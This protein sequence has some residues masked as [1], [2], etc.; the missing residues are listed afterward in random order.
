[1]NHAMFPDPSS[2]RP[3]T[4][5][6][7][8]FGVLGTLAIWW[9]EGCIEIAAAKHRTVLA[10]LL[11]NPNRTVNVGMLI[12][13]LWP[14]LAPSTARKTVQGYVWRLRRALG[15]FADRLVTTGSGYRMVLPADGT[16]VLEF[17]RSVDTARVA[18][19]A[20]ASERA[21]GELTRALDLW[22]GP[23]FDCVPRSPAIEAYA[24]RLD[25]AYVAAQESLI[26]TRLS[27]GRPAEVVPDLVGLAAAHPHRE[28]LH[29][30]LMTALHRTGRRLDALDVF[31]RLR[32]RL[33]ADYGLE[34]DR[35]TVELHQ[36]LLQDRVD[37]AGFPQR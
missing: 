22:R 34:P 30:H 14:G 35:Q 29:R 37:V 17:E 32:F 9:E 21:V 33:A 7:L 28:S 4:L 23:A 26:A 18:L 2:R 36:A 8:R 13:E 1:M 3:N 31:R 6:A 24:V 15:P 25:E 20:G 10:I 12:D 11:A 5:G 19:H 27:L 16:D